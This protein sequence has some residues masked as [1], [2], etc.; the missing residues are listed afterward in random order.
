MAATLA[1]YGG[2]FSSQLISKIRDALGPGQMQ[3][4]V[5]L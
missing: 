2:A 3:L 1:I 4:S 5:K